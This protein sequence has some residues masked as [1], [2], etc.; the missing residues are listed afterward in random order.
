[1]VWCGEV[2]CSAVLVWFGRREAQ[3]AAVQAL[4]VCWRGVTGKPRQRWAENAE[5]GL[6]GRLTTDAVIE[7]AFVEEG[8]GKRGWKT[9]DGLFHHKRS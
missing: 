6:G 4:F 3:D 1:M 7:R 5:H 9:D 2:W 8:Y